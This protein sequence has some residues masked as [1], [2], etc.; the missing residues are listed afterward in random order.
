M[1]KKTEHMEEADRTAFVQSRLRGS[2][3][4]LQVGY[5]IRIE[6]TELGSSKRCTRQ[7]REA[8]DTTWNIL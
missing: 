6:K 5:R 8:M 2:M 7:R 4:C 3:C 1:A